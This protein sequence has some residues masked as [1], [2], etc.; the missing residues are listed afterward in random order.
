MS[1]NLEIAIQ[2]KVRSL[3]DEQ[4]QQ[5]MAFVEALEPNPRDHQGKRFSFVGIARSGKGSLSIETDS[6]LDD[7]AERREGWSLP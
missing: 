1:A 2:E 5:V 4:Q 3:S 7:A 6:M